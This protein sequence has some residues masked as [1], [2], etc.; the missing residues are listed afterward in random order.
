M[1]SPVFGIDFQL[2]MLTGRPGVARLTTWPLSLYIARTL[3]SDVPATNIWKVYIRKNLLL[4]ISIF[5]RVKRFKTNN[6]M[7][8]IP[9][10][11]LVN[12][13]RCI[14]A[15]ATKPRPVSIL[16]SN[17]TPSTGP[18]GSAVMSI[19]SACAII[20]WTSSSRPTGK[21]RIE[22]TLV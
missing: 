5:Q 6:S 2:I 7:S 1:I 21:S 16:V 8:Y 13:P 12:V 4:L 14:M 18:I 20:A 22:Q 15:D 3:H 19:A 9:T 11:P 10:C 17:T